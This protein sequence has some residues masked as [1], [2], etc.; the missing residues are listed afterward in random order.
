MTRPCTVLRSVCLLVAV[1]AAGCRANAPL[2][3]PDAART[4][5]IVL[6]ASPSSLVIRPGSSGRI[7]FSVVDATGLP[8]ADYPVDFAIAN[9]SGGEDTAGAKLSTQHSLTSA[10]GD[11]VVEIIV[12]TLARNDRP[13]IFAVQATCPGST[14][15][16]AE[17]TVTTNAYS[18]E[19]LPVPADD[20]LG[21][22][23]VV[24]TRLYFYDNAACADLDLNDIGASEGQAR[25]PHVNPPFVFSGVAATGVHA[26]LGIGL[27]GSGVVR[28]GG[29]VDVPG[30]ALHES[31]TIHAIL[32]MD[33]LFPV[34][35]GAFDVASDFQLNP[36]PPALTTIRSAWQQWARCPLDPARLWIDCTIAALG[37]T[38]SLN[39]TICVPGPGTVGALGD[40]LIASRGTVV[41]PLATTLA[42]PSDTPCH[43]ATDSAGNPSL[44]SAV[45]ALFSAARGPIS[46]ANLGAFATELATLLDDIR[47]DSRMTISQSSDA[48]NYRVDHDLLAISFPDALLPVSFKA[49]VLGLPVTTARGI[50][51]TLKA[52]QLS[53]E[54][55]AFTL[56]LGTSARYAFEA[57]SL[58]SRSAEDSTA[59]V[60]AIF[61]QARWSEQDTVLTGCAAMDAIACDHTHQPRGC[62]LD[63]C[64]AGLTALGRALAGVFDN[65]D[66]A[67]LDFRLS[68]SAPVIDLDMDG[69]A[70]AL[71]VPGSAGGLI[72]GPGLWS[73]EIDA[74]AGSYLTYGSWSASRATVSH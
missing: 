53:I 49:Q 2:S 61:G 44:E 25:A 60:E 29:C 24:S 64:Q 7:R 40:L 43:G 68:G 13:A 22:A 30:S 63:A 42:T 51:A 41:A 17:I 58:K 62:L 67:G 65:L 54:G 55:H 37:N 36:A 66:G 3:L 72:A 1:A 14:G 31:E 59:L 69:R 35:S 50:L 57:S 28:V 56:R 11:A 19:I 18:V 21:S 48:N 70:D 12:G 47:I 8:V 26:V 71:G 5:G 74:R 73:G 38:A 34:P 52:D 27:D 9:E 46:A 45:D 16:Q 6:R 39:G 4:G 32:L 15:A 20:L 33:H 10:S 23:S